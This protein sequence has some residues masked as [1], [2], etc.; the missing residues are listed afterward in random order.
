MT[1]SMHRWSV[2]RWFNCGL[3][4]LGS[5]RPGPQRVPLAEGDGLAGD[6]Q[7]GK[8]LRWQGTASVELS[9]EI[10]LSDGIMT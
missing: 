9:F 3:G 8:V 1:E 2:G 6:C 10:F 7:L 4:R 5:S